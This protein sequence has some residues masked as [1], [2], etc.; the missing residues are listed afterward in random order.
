MTDREYEP[1]D[2]QDAALE[3]A[4]MGE[5]ETVDPTQG[6]TGSQSM[7]VWEL[8]L[9]DGRPTG[10]WK[11]SKCYATYRTALKAQS[12]CGPT[13]CRFCNKPTDRARYLSCTAC[14]K[15]EKS[16]IEA[17]RFEKAEKLG[18]WDGWVYCEGFGR[19]DGFFE[20]LEALYEHLQDNDELTAEHWPKYAYV[21]YPVSFAII[22][23]EHLMDQIQENDDAYEDFDPSKL[24][25]CEELKAAINAF[26]EAN[27]GVVSYHPDPSRVVLIEPPPD[28]AFE[29]CELAEQEE[30]T[31]TTES[32]Q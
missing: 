11:C 28:G 16:R 27:K 6:T 13:I 20:S 32:A 31:G 25:G 21:C 12:C 7:N 26:N 18:G 17:E 29:S 30:G 9:T 1:I 15:A 10:L 19:Q 2:A 8:F 23:F 5:T 14:D 4:E 22:D 24:T 3:L